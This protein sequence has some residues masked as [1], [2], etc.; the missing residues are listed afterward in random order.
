MRYLYFLNL[1]T[2]TSKRPVRQID[3][4]DLNGKVMENCYYCTKEDFLKTVK[5]E[6]YYGVPM[7]VNVFRDE[8]GQTIP[9]DFVKNFD[10]LP[11]GFKI[12]YYKEGEG[13]N[14]KIID[15][16]SQKPI[17]YYDSSATDMGNNPMVGM[18]VACAVAVEEACK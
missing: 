4:L 13:L 16:E 14:T 11:Q 12:F 3:F 1:N 17:F 5:E 15:F 18:T 7:A 9:L 10:P 8:N 6:N 2:L